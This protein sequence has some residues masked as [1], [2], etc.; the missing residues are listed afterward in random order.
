MSSGIWSI[1]RLSL[2]I[3]HI[4]GCQIDLANRSATCSPY[5]SVFIRIS[6]P[7]KRNAAPEGG[8]IR[9]GLWLVLC[10]LFKDNGASWLQAPSSRHWTSCFGPSLAYPRAAFA[11]SV[12]AAWLVA[13]NSKPLRNLGFWIFIMSNVLWV[14]WGIH[15]S[16]YA[17]LALQ[18]CLAAMNVRGLL[19]TED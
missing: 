16:A 7:Q 9:T 6:L 17:L 13:S 11:A 1:A 12:A 14:A 4:A 19:K 2:G 10:S 3:E 18:F 5:G 8:G 15:T